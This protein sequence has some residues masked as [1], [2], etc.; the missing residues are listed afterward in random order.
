MSSSFELFVDNGG[1][2]PAE[3]DGCDRGSGRRRTPSGNGG[4][5]DEFA[6]LFG[7]SVCGVTGVVDSGMGGIGKMGELFSD[8]HGRDLKKLSNS[9]PELRLRLVRRL[10]G[11][12]SKTLVFRLPVLERR[13]NCLRRSTRGRL[14]AT[15]RISASSGI[16]GASGAIENMR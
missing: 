14:G 11:M 7:V 10:A 8:D 4:S 2:T 15:Y 12:S 3:V 1:L 6:S 9:E 16:G 5:V 13:F